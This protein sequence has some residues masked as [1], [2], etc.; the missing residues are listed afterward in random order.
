M[1]LAVWLFAL[2]GCGYITWVCYLSAG[3]LAAVLVGA[4]YFGGLG[5]LLLS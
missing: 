3:V 2:A 5:Y 4:L 1:R